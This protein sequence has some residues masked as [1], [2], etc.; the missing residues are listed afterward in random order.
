MRFFSNLFNISN[1]SNLKKEERAACPPESGNAFTRFWNSFFPSPKSK[2]SVNINTA[3]GVSA[4]FRCIDIIAGGIASLSFQVFEESGGMIQPAKAHPL[5]YPLSKEPHEHYTK[6]TFF[7]TL[8]ANTLLY[9]NGYAIIN[10]H[11]HTAR[12]VSYELVSPQMV[13]PF[14][15]D[16]GELYYKVTV[17]TIE[18]V[19]NVFARDMIHIS[20]LS[21]N[22][23][24]GVDLIRKNAEN[25]GVTIAATQYAGAFFGNG[26]H[27]AGVIERPGSLSPEALD[28]IRSSFNAN[29][30]GTGKTGSTAVLDEGMTYKKIGMSPSD[31]MLVEVRKFQVE[32][33]SRIFGPPL[34][35]LNAMERATF[36]NVEV[37]DQ[38]FVK[39]TLRP[40]CKMIEE[41]IN[42]KSFTQQEKQS[43]RYYTRFNLSSML[44]GDTKTR[45][46]YF[47]TMFEIGALS[48][49]D[50]RKLENMNPRDGG[51][52]YFTPLNFTTNP[53]QI[54]ENAE[55]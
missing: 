44:R 37:M 28:K 7:R 14:M 26:A 33:I 40:W 9:G 55:A 10:R 19:R 12:P 8:I 39:H 34:H 1:N 53:E 17:K 52:E 22:G 2:V 18:K 13:E 31:A 43:G 50:I 47:R 32:E 15:S 6:F 25:I 46:E 5:Y 30:S 42:R 38:A 11:P 35:M 3:L 41:E 54:N 27:V 4:I 51:N 49:N 45:A 23:L 21:L 16:M 29:Y 48:P 24:T 20:T 36:N